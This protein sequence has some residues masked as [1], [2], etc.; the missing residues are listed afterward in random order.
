MPE[1]LGRPDASCSI[2]SNVINIGQTFGID[3]QSQF[4]MDISMKGISP[5]VSDSCVLFMWEDTDGDNAYDIDMEDISDLLP[6][7]ECEVFSSVAG[8]SFFFYNDPANGWY[9]YN[10]Q[11]DVESVTT[12][13]LDGASIKNW[14]PM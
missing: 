4:T 9:L 2:V 12:A 1:A 11:G 6:T 10:R 7:G 5:E 8:A 3:D 14:S 13:H